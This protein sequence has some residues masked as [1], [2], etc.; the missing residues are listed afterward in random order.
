MRRLIVVCILL[1]AVLLLAGAAVAGTDDPGTVVLTLNTGQL[2]VVMCNEGDETVEE[3]DG[4]VLVW[5]EKP[6]VTRIG[7]R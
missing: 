6:A 3:A 1:A 5:C 2:A 7:P 4:V